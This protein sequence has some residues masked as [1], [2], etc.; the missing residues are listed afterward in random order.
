MEDQ[1]RALE[2]LSQERPDDLQLKVDVEGFR[3]QVDKLKSALDPLKDKFDGIFKDAGANLFGDLMNGT[4]PLAALKNFANAIGKQINDTVA[5]D[6]SNQV[7]GKGGIFGGAGG[8]LADLF[9]GKERKAAELANAANTPQEAFRRS[10][11]AAGNLASPEATAK[12]SE[13][14]ASTAAAG[15]L[16]ELDSAAR[17]AAAAL[18]EIASR[19]TGVPPTTGD[20]ARL[21]RSP[22][23]GPTTGDFARLDRGQT[24]G[25][26]SVLDMF[27]DASKSSETLGDSNTKAA[28][29]ALQLASA[30]VRGGG[31]LG[32]LPSIVQSIITAAQAAS[33]SSSGGGLLGGLAGLFGG[34]GSAAGAVDFGTTSGEAAALFWSTGGY[35]GGT[36]PKKPAGI[37]HGK[38]YVFSAPAVQAIGVDR[39]ERLHNK[40]KTGRVNEG[41][42][43]GYADGGYVTVLGSARP[44]T[45][46]SGAQWVMAQPTKAG[47]TYI[48]HHHNYPVTVHAPPNMS[49]QTAMQAGK[50]VG[51][52]IELARK[53]QG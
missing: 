30:A 18:N 24:S 5:K 6:L 26:Q 21:D 45:L 7:F 52:G 34:G 4:K 17:A 48:T 49:R 40:A 53:R 14:T 3:L 16:N 35:T 44:Q 8:S 29:A 31:A 12:Q 51:R 9:G 42:V 39:L 10:E 27:R 23:E 46:Q 38:E 33:A 19:G 28:S 20:F 15:A 25:E 11:I 36:D 32:S 1:L 37:V 43:P 2:K 41:E 13:T 22:V 47:D 50:D